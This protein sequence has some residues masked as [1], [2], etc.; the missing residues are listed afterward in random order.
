VTHLELRDRL[1]DWLGAN[2]KRIA[3]SVRTDILNIA[4]KELCRQWDL[5]FNE[6]LDTFD[7]VASA[8]SYPLPADFSR[9]YEMQYRDPDSQGVVTVRFLLLDEFDNLYPDPTKTGKPRHY[10]MWGGNFYLGP[11]PDLVVTITRGYYRYLPDLVGDNDTNALTEKA[12]EVL[13]FK[14]LG[15]MSRYG[16]EDERIPVW[17]ARGGELE[18][19]MVREHARAKSAGRRPEGRE[20]S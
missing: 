14:G 2:A 12:W 5:S 10:T 18:L 11:T 9:P 16:L 15:D 7:T 6:V 13:L 20:A 4:Q 19:E 3:P 1:G 17:Q 8:N